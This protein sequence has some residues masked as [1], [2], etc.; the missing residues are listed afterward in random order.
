MLGAGAGGDGLRRRS[1]L[2][3]SFLFHSRRR[4][5]S[6]ARISAGLRHRLPAAAAR[7]ASRP[8]VASRTFCYFLASLLRLPAALRLPPPPPAAADSP[9]SPR[10]PAASPHPV[11]SPPPALPP[12]GMSCAPS[13]EAPPPAPGP[14]PGRRVRPG[15]GEG[16]GA[17]TRAGAAHRGAGARPR[18][19]FILQSRVAGTRGLSS[20][21]ADGG[22]SASRCLP[23]S[24]AGRRREAAGIRGA[25]SL[26]VPSTG[27]G[28]REPRRP[29]GCAGLEG[30]GR[31]LWRPRRWPGCEQRWAWT[32]LRGGGPRWRPSSPSVP[33]DPAAGAPS[34]CSKT[35]AGALWWPGRGGRGTA[36]RRDSLGASGPG[37]RRTCQALPGFPW[38][39]KTPRVVWLLG[40]GGFGVG[41]AWASSASRAAPAGP[42]RP[43]SVGRPSLL[44]G[45]PD[46]SLSPAAIRS[47]KLRDLVESEHL[48]H[49]LHSPT[50]LRRI[51]RWHI[52]AWKHPFFEAGETNPEFP[53]TYFAH[54]LPMPTCQRARTCGSPGPNLQGL[55]LV[56]ENY[57]FPC[58]RLALPL[59]APWSGL[60]KQP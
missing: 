26:R 49:S 39:S 25:L 58:M 40:G 36:W 27:R 59:G 7:P 42:E 14:A 32:G 4:G 34:H 13:A 29:R 55:P 24:E 31:L 57:R 15:T 10:A 21:A 20:P 54:L 46:L 51:P 45:P 48:P 1:F 9:P 5:P 22:A 2:F 35:G 38:G 60:G 28:G 8:R 47:R 3:G 41:P 33:P 23:R 56:L 6:P 52:C 17:G 18:G 11:S 12:S 16:A 53:P 44:L 19:H 30:G 50:L 43:A 37:T